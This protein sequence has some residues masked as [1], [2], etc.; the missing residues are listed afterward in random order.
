VSGAGSSTEISL[1]LLDA[2]VG[3]GRSDYL[4]E[5]VGFV[6]SVAGAGYEPECPHPAHVPLKPKSGRMLATS[7][8]MKAALGAVLLAAGAL[9]LTGFDKV[10][11]AAM[12]R[13]AP[14]WLVDL[15][16]RF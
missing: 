9:V 10:F 2:G 11:E 8:G 3:I 6:S 5:I 13:A 7:S 15:T 1:I 16:T 14:S 4:A 12:V